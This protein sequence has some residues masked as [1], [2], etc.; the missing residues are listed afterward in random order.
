MEIDFRQQAR[1]Y[2]GV[3]ELELGVWFRAFCPRG[4]S[5]F[6]VGAREGYHTLL[7]A[8]LSAGGRVLAF[9]AD[10]DEHRRLCRNIAANPEFA[11]APEARLARV[12]AGA[13]P[14]DV[15]LDRFAFG[16]DGFVPDVVKLD[17]EGWELR[18]LEGARRLLAERRPHL[19]VETHSQ[20][21]ER[22][23]L[24]LLRSH[25]YAPVVVHP[26]AWLAEVR[27]GHNRWL[28]AEGTSP[29]ADTAPKRTSPREIGTESAQPPA[30]KG[31]IVETEG[32]GRYPTLDGWG[33]RGS[34]P[35]DTA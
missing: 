24:G 15:T 19:I 28:V 32:G 34:S 23:C 4:A 14:D 3:F 10:P 33:N 1:M 22:D 7:M 27:A 5:A 26:R 20:A 31:V 35:A 17:V 21:L 12:T 8:R 16:D 25:G 18:A 2:L 29:K 9:E 30:G 6:D 13:R 11:P